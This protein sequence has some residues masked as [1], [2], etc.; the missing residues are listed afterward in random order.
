MREN[1]VFKPEWVEAITK[2]PLHRHM[3]QH[4][5][6]TSSGHDSVLHLHLKEKGHSFEDSNVHVVARE[7]RWFER[8]VKEAIYVHI[9]K[10]SL[11]RGGELRCHFFLQAT[12]VSCEPSPGSLILICTW[13]P[14]DL[15]VSHETRVE[16]QTLLSDLHLGSCDLND[17]HD[18]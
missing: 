11:N 17:S 9:E 5:G 1:Q 7:D 12:I 13:R 3:A 6:A 16:G 10:T 18:A 14:C 8:G 2:Q 4:G 15:K